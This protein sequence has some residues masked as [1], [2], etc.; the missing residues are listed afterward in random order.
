LVSWPDPEQPKPSGEPTSPVVLATE[1]LTFLL[2][3]AT[4]MEFF[5]AKRTS[6]D[7]HAAYTNGQVEQLA[8]ARQALAVHPRVAWECLATFRTDLDTPRFPITSG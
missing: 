2:Y 5:S 4:L 7:Y 3:A 8:R 1:L 6:T